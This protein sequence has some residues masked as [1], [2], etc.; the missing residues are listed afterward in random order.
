M[1]FRSWWW[2]RLSSSIDGGQLG[3]GFGG[4]VAWV[5]SGFQWV[6]GCGFGKWVF[7]LIFEINEF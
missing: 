2:V 6:V 5:I 1:L 7:I 4:L 3:V